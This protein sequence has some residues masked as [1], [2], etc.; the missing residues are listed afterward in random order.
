MKA[1]QV[2]PSDPQILYKLG[3]SHYANQDY[4]LCIRYH[5]E[6]IKKFP[7][8][9]YLADTYYHIGLAYCNLEKFEKSIF[10]YTKVSL[11]SFLM[12]TLFYF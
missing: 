11:F 8:Y 12:L 6:C 5:K 10:P 4:K 9:T 1:L 7:Y 3:L 2:E